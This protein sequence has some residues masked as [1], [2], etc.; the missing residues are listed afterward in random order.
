M[1]TPAQPS[2]RTHPRVSVETLCSEV[3]DDW[4]QP[5]LV[6]DLS[7]SGLRIERPLIPARPERVLQLEIELPEVDEIMWAKAELCF[8]LY[9]IRSQ[10]D[11]PRGV[12]TS[13]VRLVAAATRHLRLLR[14]YVMSRREA[15]RAFRAAGQR[16]LAERGYVSANSDSPS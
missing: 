1:H 10:H 5:A 11:G 9:S 3:T 13:G 16:L 14:D 2:V 8:E 4:E 7:E 15:E 12:R 6:L